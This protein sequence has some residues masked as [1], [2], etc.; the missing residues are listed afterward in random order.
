MEE[1]LK[2]TD[3]K[4]ASSPDGGRLAVANEFLNED[5]TFLELEWAGL[6]M[7]LSVVVVIFVNSSWGDLFSVGDSV[8][9]ILVLASAIVGGD[10]LAVVGDITVVD[11][12]VV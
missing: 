9:L 3:D 1:E 10:D 6:L 8:T 7:L 11:L 4:A 5:D 12:G 2:V